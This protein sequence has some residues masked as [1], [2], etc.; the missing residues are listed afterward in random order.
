MGK[1]SSIYVKKKSETS[2]RSAASK[3]SATSGPKDHSPLS[4][5]SKKAKF[6]DIEFYS[7]QSDNT[8]NFTCFE[9]DGKFVNGMNGL[10][11]TCPRVKASYL[12]ITITWSIEILTEN[13]KPVAPDEKKISKLANII[14]LLCL[15]IILAVINNTFYSNVPRQVDT[16]KKQAVF[17]ND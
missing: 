8:L 13:L 10:N 5:Q 15:E 16:L 3:A 9:N 7:Q 2:Q 1:T 17:L 12:M 11:Q 4:S 14:F 6:G